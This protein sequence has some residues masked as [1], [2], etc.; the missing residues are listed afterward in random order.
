MKGGTIGVQM[1]KW[2]VIELFDNEQTQFH[3]G[4]MSWETKEMKI[5]TDSTYQYQQC[6]NF[7]IKN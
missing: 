2:L 1:E 7:I 6:P 3:I 5:L 4:L